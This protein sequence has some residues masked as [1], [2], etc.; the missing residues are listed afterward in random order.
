MRHDSDTKPVVDAVNDAISALSELL[1]SLRA[2]ARASVADVKSTARTVK[3]DAVKAGRSAAKSGK[4]TAEAFG[5]GLLERVTKA[6]HDLTGA[7]EAPKA[8]SA[9]PRRGRKP[10]RAR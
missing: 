3:R 8:R 4:T 10:R 1:R 6:W 9:A 2:H 5:D 7:D